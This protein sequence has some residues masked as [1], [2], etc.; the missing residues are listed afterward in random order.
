[1][2]LFGVLMAALLVVGLAAGTAR[3]EE[4]KVVQRKMVVKCGEDGECRVMC[5]EGEESGTT[6]KYRRACGYPTPNERTKPRHGGVMGGGSKQSGNGC[7]RACRTVGSD[8]SRCPR[9]GSRLG[10]N[11]QGS[12]RH[13]AV[14]TPQ[15]TP[16]KEQPSV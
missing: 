3:A 12:C 7:T 5:G 16:S 4:E 2:K 10:Q 9:I 8:E 14:C 11:P 13:G 15:V 1:M 6:T